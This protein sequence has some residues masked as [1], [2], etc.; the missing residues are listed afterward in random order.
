MP[1]D[2][3]HDTSHL[4]IESRSR[5]PRIKTA[6]WDVETNGLLDT[7]TRIH[8]LVIRDFE[9]RITYKFRRND[10]MDN[11]DD[12]LDLLEQAELNV[13]FNNIYFDIPAIDKVYEGFQIQGKT[14]DA[15]VMSRMVFADQKEKDFRLFE[16]GKIPGKLIGHHTL[17]AWGY[18]LGM[19]KG[20]YKQI[21]EARA[22][23]LGIT[24]PEMLTNFVWGTWNQ[25]MEDYCVLDVEVTTL[26]WDR[27]LRAEWAETAT[28]LEH[29]IHDLMGQQERN[30]IP[31]NVPE[32][33]KLAEEL[34]GQVHAL[35]RQAI[36]HYGKW[37]KP[38]KKR[39]VRPLW[40]DPDGLNKAKSYEKPR[41]EF[42]EDESRAVWGDVTVPKKRTKY[43]DTLRGTYDPEAPFCKVSLTEFNPNSR[44]Q[45]VDRFATVYNWHPVDF[46]DSGQ[47]EVSDDV[48]RKLIDHIPMAYELAE[49]FYYNKRL[50]QL[51]TGKNA[52]LKKVSSDG[53]I[54][55]YV[56][57]GGTVS[58]RASH[59]SPNLAQVPK[60]KVKKG[61]GILLGREGDHGFECRD[62]FYVPEPW[63]MT[64]IDLSGIEL[65]CFG[66][67]LRK[68]DGGEYLRKVLE[69]DIHTFNQEAA[70]LPTRDMAKTF[71][72]ACVPMDTLAL[73][74]DGWKGYNGLQVGEPVLTYNAAKHCKEWKPVLEKVRY[75]DADV[76]E[77]KNEQ[78]F[79]VRCTP[80]H[81]WFTTKRSTIKS[82]NGGHSRTWRHEVC[83]AED[84]TTEHNIIINAPM[85]DDSIVWGTMNC[86][87]EPKYETNWV[88][89]I[90]AMNQGERNA[91]MSG[92][93]LADGHHQ[94]TG[95]NKKNWKWT[96]SQNDGA[97][98]D[99]AIIAS[100]L[101]WDGRVIITDKRN[102]LN[103]R[104]IIIANETTR[105]YVTC[106]RLQKIPQPS[107]DVWCIRTENESW[108]MRQGSTITITGNTLYGAGD[109]KIG[110][111]VSP[112]A[113]EEE[114]AKIGA[115]LKQRFIRNIPAYGLLTKEV[116]RYASRGFIPGLDG[117]RLYVRSKHSAL[118]TWLQSDAALISKKW[119][120]LTEEYLLDQ[121]LEHGWD[122]DF[123]Q[124]LYIHDELQLAS[125]GY[126]SIVEQ[127]SIRAARDAG[128]HFGYQAPI[129]ADAK[130]GHT[131]AQTH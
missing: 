51:K 97:I 10:V 81:R 53:K 75:A 119:A 18:R 117:R 21:M 113:S 9:R 66:E 121:G 78:T 2:A 130:H 16:R 115:G 108:V 99:A 48:L 96:W 85:E 38:A 50:G 35:E 22:K 69:S 45:I 63:E 122:A 86:H 49:V 80:N 123:V 36:E 102:P 14:R 73:T 68:Y 126:G 124:L 89:Q 41:L 98:A 40:D 3:V 20:D 74:K 88:S 6:L 70:G 30:G 13:G 56:N 61:I 95:P 64:G 26:F 82:K 103:N 37:W 39:I 23:E 77:L 24:D 110:S 15:M 17:E 42:G 7:L 84:L 83:T 60:V 104:K 62:L 125:R 47:P 94:A 92:F 31:F 120:C 131:W 34:E 72:Y 55:A 71:I 33:E 105:P 19:H 87:H 5:Y 54:R 101:V 79:S 127:C 65:R 112:L 44:Q 76:I 107:Q 129:D 1:F 46:T 57:V 25:E 91:W 27:I 11:I 52:W 58:G 100:Y 4:K 109:V 106:Q 93:C 12:G 90:L 28:V 114:Q 111:I 29:T 67:K 8:C 59:V 128:L 118:N 43:A 32:A 116:R